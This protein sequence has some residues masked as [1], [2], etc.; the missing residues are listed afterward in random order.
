MTAAPPAVIDLAREIERMGQT[1][2]EATHQ[3][4]GF[5]RAWGAAQEAAGKGRGK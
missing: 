1:A 2:A 5:R 4:E 3:L